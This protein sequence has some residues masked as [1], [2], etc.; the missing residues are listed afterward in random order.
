MLRVANLR[1]HSMV[2][3]E[4]RIMFT[5]NEPILEG[6]SFRH[7]YML[8]LDFDQLGQRFPPR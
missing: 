1:H 8:K 2:E 4:F 6:D 5:R 3:A 7:F